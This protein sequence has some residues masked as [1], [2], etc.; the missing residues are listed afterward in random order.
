[1][2]RAALL[3]PIVLAGCSIGGGSGGGGGLSGEAP[4]S[5]Q[6]QAAAKEVTAKMKE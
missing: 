6:A 2:R 1:M 3:L 5:G 4:T